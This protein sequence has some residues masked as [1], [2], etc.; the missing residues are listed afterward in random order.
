MTSGEN[1]ISHKNNN[2]NVTGVACTLSTVTRTHARISWIWWTWIH[3]GGWGIYSDVWK[4]C[5]A[6]VRMREVSGEGQCRRQES[7]YLL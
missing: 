3:V 6:C 5:G 1:V 4:H 2:H 7:L